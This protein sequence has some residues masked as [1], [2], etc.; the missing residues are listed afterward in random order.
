MIDEDAN[1]QKGTKV[2]TKPK[3]NQTPEEFL[4]CK[5]RELGRTISPRFRNFFYRELK[6]KG[7]SIEDAWRIINH[8]L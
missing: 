2:L 8:G 7:N 5:E 3:T 4:L 6:A 1:L